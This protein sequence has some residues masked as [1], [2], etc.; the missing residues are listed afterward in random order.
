MYE[1]QTSSQGLI[2][3]GWGCRKHAC[4]RDLG[5]GGSSKLTGACH[6]WPGL[7]EGTWAGQQEQ[8]ALARLEGIRICIHQA[9]QP[10]W[11]IAPCV[12]GFPQVSHPAAHLHLTEIMLL[13]MHLLARPPTGRLPG[14]HCIRQECQCCF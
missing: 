14:S 4:V 11:T 7:Q 8:V 1:T 9:G 5:V 6:A 3:R 13:L 10:L 2:M 12:P